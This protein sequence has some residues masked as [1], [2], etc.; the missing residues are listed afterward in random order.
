MYHS[1]AMPGME[2]GRKRK[3]ITACS[4]CHFLISPFLFVLISVSLFIIAEV[5]NGRLILKF[6]R[7]LHSEHCC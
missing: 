5:E 7:E 4:E 1:I 3:N 2:P 6:A